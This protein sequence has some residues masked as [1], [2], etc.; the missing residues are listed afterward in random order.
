MLINIDLALLAFVLAINALGYWLKRT[1]LG[2]SKIPLTLVLLGFSILIAIAWGYVSGFI[3]RSKGLLSYGLANGIVLWLVAINLYDIVHEF[4]KRKEKWK[5][6]FLS[7][8]KGE[9]N[10]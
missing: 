3:V 2:E 4:T 10:E 9:K 6:F 7:F 8:K 1:K 5:A